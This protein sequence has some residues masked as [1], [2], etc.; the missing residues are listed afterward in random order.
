MIA[1]RTTLLDRA[2]IWLFGDGVKQNDSG[3]ILESAD[4]TAAIEQLF[5]L[6]VSHFGCF[7]RGHGIKGR[8][9]TTLAQFG[10]SSELWELEFAFNAKGKIAGVTLD[11]ADTETIC[12]AIGERKTG[13]NACYFARRANQFPIVAQAK[14]G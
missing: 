5:A 6:P 12:R 10:S 11:E 4:Q 3:R 9:R 13:N 7:S 14:C 1:E 2:G 8:H